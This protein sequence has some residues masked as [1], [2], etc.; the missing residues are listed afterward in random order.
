M[1]RLGNRSQTQSAY[2]G[3]RKFIDHLSRVTRHDGGPQYRVRTFLD[4][5]LDK[6][7]VLTIQNG[8]V[9]VFKRLNECF[10]FQSFLL[11]FL[12]IQS[13]VGDF[14]IG[15]GAPGD[16]KCAYVGAPFEERVADYDAGH[17]VRGV[18]E[19]EPAAYVAGRV[20]ARISGLQA[21]VDFDALSVIVFH[22]NRLQA[23]AL[24]IG[25]APHA[26][27]DL[28][29]LYRFDLALAFVLHHLAGGCGRH[30]HHRAAADQVYPVPHH[31]LFHDLRGIAVFPD[32]NLFRSLE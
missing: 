20:D 2:H 19:L 4:V 31:L 9:H 32:Q 5:D 10:D 15:I 29:E 7:C 24:H 16:G 28:V 18:S 11:G 1:D 27:Q 22:A 26:H 13:H 12:I 23:Q 6:P 3:Q 21:I 8:T 25:R 17:S 30:A 14:R